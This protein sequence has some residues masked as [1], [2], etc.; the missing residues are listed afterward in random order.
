VIDG[1]DTLVFVN[2]ALSARLADDDLVRRGIPRRHVGLFV[3]RQLHADWFDDCGWV[4]RYDRPTAHSVVRQLGATGFYLRASR[5]LR[6]L[7]GSGGIRRVYL[8]NNDNLLTNH[9]LE[10]AR[11]V[12][13]CEVVVV[14]EGLMNF[15]DIRLRNRQA[16]RS[17]AKAVA[18]PLL[19]LSWD[20]PPTHL[21]GAY[22]PR[23]NRVLTFERRGLKA[24]D[25][26]IEEHRLSPLAPPS[27]KDDRTV[28]IALSGIW[29][30]I[31]PEED[32]ALSR[33][34]VEWLARQCFERVIAKPHPN[35]TGGALE[36]LLRPHER[37]DST[38]SLE[39][40]AGRITAGTVAGICCTALVTLKQLRP[41][42]RCVDYGGDFYCER[43]Y[44]GD[45]S[46]HALMRAAGVEAVAF[47][48]R[49]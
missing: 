20:P 46:V 1:I 39:D 35:V 11:R 17:H 29:Q 37:L 34:F 2:N 12:R 21:S 3:L 8:V 43:G 25:E 47:A 38:E 13:D 42:L 16:W 40:L 18:A 10:W 24:P 28:L 15:Q 36:R 14:A 31:T 30:W 41:D 27:D 33:G 49:A 23:V 44:F 19:G 22:D 9:V 4:L 26:K 32:E 6:A 5:A 7:L 45:K 48:S